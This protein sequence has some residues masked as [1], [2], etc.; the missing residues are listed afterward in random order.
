[1]ESPVP[2][3]TAGMTVIAVLALVQSALGVLRTLHWFELGSDLLAQGV[4][5]LPIMGLAAFFRGALVAII[6]S[7][8][9]LFASGVFLHRSWAWWLGMIVAVVNLLLVV[10]VMA[11][12]E[13]MMQAI[14]WLIIP[15]I[16]ISYLYFSGR[17]VFT[18]AK[19]NEP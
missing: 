4:L 1:M 11:Q 12:G 16:M 14:P 19:L 10:S 17:Q 6:V 18:S 2:K 15:V 3:R 9:V 5:F 8:Y 13:A 7:L